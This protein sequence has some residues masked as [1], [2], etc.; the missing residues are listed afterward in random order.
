MV[1]VP[2]NIN[3]ILIWICQDWEKFHLYGAVAISAWLKVEAFLG[4]FANLGSNK[5]KGLAF[6]NLQNLCG[7][8]TSPASN[9]KETAIS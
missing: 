2:A 4:I 5:K 7:S 3:V 6:K 9:Q 1:K 8:W